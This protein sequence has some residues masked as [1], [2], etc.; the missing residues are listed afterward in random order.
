M[1]QYLSDEWMEEAGAALAAGAMGA[2][3][4]VAAAAASAVEA[5]AAAARSA[6]VSALPLRSRNGTPAH[7]ELRISR[8]TS[9]RVSVL[10][11]ASTP[12]S[13]T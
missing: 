3:A 9:A 7:R 13:A 6:A 1:V 10:R 11:A 12:S 4:V 2:V 5:E 8:L